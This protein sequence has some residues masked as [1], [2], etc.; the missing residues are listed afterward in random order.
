MTDNRNTYFVIVDNTMF[1]AF[2]CQYGL[3]VTLHRDKAWSSDDFDHACFIMRE[4]KLS[5]PE[6]EVSVRSADRVL[7]PRVVCANDLNHYII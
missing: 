2:S 1:E 4:I 5:K 6:A 3:E 7:G